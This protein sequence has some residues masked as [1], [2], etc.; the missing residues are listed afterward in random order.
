M[1]EFQPVQ[2]QKTNGMAIAGFVLSLLCCTSLLG[3]IFSAVGLNQINKDPSQGGKGLALA[4][5]ILG[6]IFVVIYIIWAVFW[7]AV[8]GTAIEDIYDYGY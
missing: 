5:L 7:A 3:I 4:G 8:F 2:P 1:S 6:I